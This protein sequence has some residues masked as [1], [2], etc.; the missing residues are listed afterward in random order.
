MKLI[1]SEVYDYMLDEIQQSAVAG[2]KNMKT[3]IDHLKLQADANVKIGPY[4]ETAEEVERL[5][6]SAAAKIDEL[7][8]LGVDLEALAGGTPSSEDEDITIIQTISHEMAIEQVGRRMTI[9]AMIKALLD[10]HK[11]EKVQHNSKEDTFTIFK[12]KN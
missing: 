12:E 11:A 8:A 3:A 5:L 9:G 2:Y 6:R 10:F 4:I 1:T 7:P